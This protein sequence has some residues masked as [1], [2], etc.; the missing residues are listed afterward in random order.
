M[1]SCCIC[2]LFAFIWQKKVKHR[3]TCVNV[4]IRWGCLLVCGTEVF[5][6]GAFNRHRPITTIVCILT[7]VYKTG[8]YTFFIIMMAQRILL[9]LTTIECFSTRV[10]TVMCSKKSYMWWVKFKFMNFRN[11]EVLMKVHNWWLHHDK[12]FYCII[13]CSYNCICIS[14]IQLVLFIFFERASTMHITTCNVLIDMKNYDWSNILIVLILLWTW[15]INPLT[16]CT[17]TQENSNVVMHI[18]MMDMHTLLPLSFKMMSE[19][20]AFRVA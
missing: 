9:I 1:C 20:Y 4:K 5:Q 18:L 16:F 15:K 19:T 3:T 10:V 6:S 8:Y 17:T 7:L 11:I 2:V 13:F 12:L 14:L